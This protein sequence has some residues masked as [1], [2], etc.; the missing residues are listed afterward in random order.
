MRA[1]PGR[2]SDISRAAALSRELALHATLPQLALDG[3][4]ITQCGG[5][6][7]EGGAHL[8]PA[9]AIS[10]FTSAIQFSTTTG[11]TLS[12]PV[13]DFTKTKCLP[14]ADTS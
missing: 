4:A 9:A 6:T 1:A 3:V 7:I 14:S 8:I 2:I 12:S 5:E 13:S 11:S 10:R